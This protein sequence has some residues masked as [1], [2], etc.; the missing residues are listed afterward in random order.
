L[1]FGG[2]GV[3]QT[4]AGVTR[5]HVKVRDGGVHVVDV[6]AELNPEGQQC[7]PAQWDAHARN[8][9]PYRETESPSK[10]PLETRI[11]IIDGELA[12][13]SPRG[14]GGAWGAFEVFYREPVGIAYTL[15]TAVHSTVDKAAVE[16]LGVPPAASFLCA[17]GDGPR[18]IMAEQCAGREW[19]RLD[20]LDAAGSGQGRLSALS[21]SALGLLGPGEVMHVAVSGTYRLRASDSLEGGPR[22]LVVDLGAGY[23]Y[24]L[25]LWRSQPGVVSELMFPTGVVLRVSAPRYSCLMTIRDSSFDEYPTMPAGT[26]FEDTTRGLVFTVEHI[27]GSE[28]TISFSMLPTPVA[29]GAPAP[30]LCG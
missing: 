13:S 23:R 8:E 5:R 21:L 3:K 1:L 9:V 25:E 27:D 19:N 14:T 30:V 6:P 26:Q 12:C 4:L 17:V 22:L 7:Q 2:K 15:A 16:A 20:P 11:Y 28:A 10:I 29:A 18:V 24:G